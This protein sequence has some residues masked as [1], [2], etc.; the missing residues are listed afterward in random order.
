[1]SCPSFPSNQVRLALFA[2]AYNPGNFLLRFALPEK[3]SHWSL[4][5]VQLELIKRDA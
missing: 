3:I 1:M 2:L 5:S 4:S